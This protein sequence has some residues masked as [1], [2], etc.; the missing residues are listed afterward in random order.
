MTQ[1]AAIERGAL[2]AH[3]AKSVVRYR[4]LHDE[5]AAI[6]KRRLKKAMGCFARLC[7]GFIL[8]DM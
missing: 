1:I 3:E 2:V 7:V 8:P 6:Q 4:Q 5:I